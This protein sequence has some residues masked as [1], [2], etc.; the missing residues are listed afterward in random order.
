MIEQE[1]RKMKMREGGLKKVLEIMEFVGTRH[2]YDKEVSSVD[3]KEIKTKFG[4]YDYWLFHL[5]CGIPQK[6]Q[7]K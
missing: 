1:E 7:K 6:N 5:Y 3:E 2:N 4:E